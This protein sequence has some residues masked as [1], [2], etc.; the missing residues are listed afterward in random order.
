VADRY[1][2]ESGSPDG[3]LLEDG[4]GVLLLNNSVAWEWDNSSHF[5]TLSS[6]G[7]SATAGQDSDNL[8]KANTTL[9]S[10][11][12][13]LTPNMAFGGNVN[14]GFDDLADSTATWLGTGTNST[15]Y[16]SNGSIYSGGSTVGSSFATFTTSDV[17]KAEIVAGKAYFY[18]NGT[19]QNTGGT[20]LPAGLTS[21]YPTASTNKSG[22]ILAAD[23]TGWTVS[24]N[25]ISGTA[26]LSFSPSATL[27]G[28]GSISGS[29]TLTLTPSATLL[30]QGQVSGSATLTFTPS[31]TGLVERISGTS[32]L[33]LNPS[34]TLL[35]KGA[36]TGSSTLTFAPSATL[37]GTGQVVGSSTL[38]LNG[39]ATITQP[40]IAGSTSFSFAPS[41]T[42]LGKGAV[43][44]TTSLSLTSSAT[45][46]GRGAI[47]GSSSLALTVSGTITGAGALLGSTAISL[48]LTGALT[49]TSTNNIS[50]SAM[51]LFSMSA[52]LRGIQLPAVGLAALDQRLRRHGGSWNQ[53]QRVRR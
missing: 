37:L 9:A 48:V 42:L 17:I 7:L 40:T 51:I 21:P 45:L 46:L 4:S 53:Y 25:N 12:F 50:G 13:T 5:Y 3:Y 27:L 14:V 33:T 31:A 34:G 19:L 6:D 32:S 43:T 29:S 11:Y 52:T 41:A 22:N 38:V 30:G 8:A 2:L 20:T 16:G 47:V 35:G 1:L 26:T 24:S 15:A 39:S 23:F 36:V 28:S 49:E 18:K 10:G 44:G